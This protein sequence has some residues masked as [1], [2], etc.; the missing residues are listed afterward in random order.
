MKLIIRV[1]NAFDVIRSTAMV[2]DGTWCRIRAEAAEMT[3][4]INS[5]KQIK[6]SMTILSTSTGGLIVIIEFPAKET[7]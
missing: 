3:G 6:N 7:S 4:N 5:L 1:K 2:E